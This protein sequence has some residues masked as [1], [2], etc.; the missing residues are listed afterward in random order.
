M[1]RVKILFLSLF[2]LGST[3]VHA[4]DTIT[5]VKINPTWVAPE[6]IFKSKTFSES[7]E[8]SII[9]DKSILKDSLDINDNMTIHEMYNLSNNLETMISKLSIERDRFVKDNAN[10]EVIQLKKEAINFLIKNKKIVDLTILKI[11]L[12]DEQGILLSDRQK[13]KRYLVW[14]ISIFSILV[15]TVLVLWQRIRIKSKNNEIIK[16]LSVVNKKNT[17]HSI[18]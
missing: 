7:E 17:Y 10:Y 4:Q 16:Q 12:S 15:L 5:N 6:E 2:I 11:K 14:S 1:V 13:L 9:S 3:L 18:I 8:T